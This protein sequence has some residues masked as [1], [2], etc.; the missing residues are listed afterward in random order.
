VKLRLGLAEYLK[1]STAREM[2]TEID[3]LVES[4]VLSDL[5]YSLVGPKPAPPAATPAAAEHAAPP[6]TPHNAE[7]QADDDGLDFIEL[8]GMYPAFTPDGEVPTGNECATRTFDE[9]GA[10]NDSERVLAL[11][12]TVTRAGRESGVKVASGAPDAPNQGPGGYTEASL[13]LQERVPF[14]LARVPWLEIRVRSYVVV[15]SDTHTIE[16]H[17]QLRLVSLESITQHP[18]PPES[19]KGMG[20]ARLP[21]EPTGREAR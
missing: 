4:L 13:W 16:C 14:V 12:K 9:C 15:K 8:E 19:C 17:E 2:S 6:S 20:G 3:T 18:E 21:L 1:A 7:V 10:L 5:S 11:A